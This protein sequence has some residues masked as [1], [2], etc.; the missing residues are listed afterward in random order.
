MSLL[1]CPSTGLLQAWKFPMC[2]KLWVCRSEVWANED[3]LSTEGHGHF[4]PPAYYLNGTD[5]DFNERFHQALSVC[6]IFSTNV[7]QSWADFK[8]QAQSSHGAPSPTVEKPQS[9]LFL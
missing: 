2:P 7:K 6:Y 1:S 9:S 3:L 5:P 4:L 8:A